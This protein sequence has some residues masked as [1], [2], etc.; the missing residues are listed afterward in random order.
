MLQP[1]R[2]ILSLVVFGSLL[3]GISFTAD[4][5]P[6]KRATD[7]HSAHTQK[8][9]KPFSSDWHRPHRTGY[10]QPGGYEGRIGSPYY[11]SIP[12][13]PAVSRW[14][15]HWNRSHAWRGSVGH[16]HSCSC[17]QHHQHHGSHFRGDQLR[18]WH[19]SQRLMSNPY[20]YHFGHGYYR[21]HEHGHYRF[22]YYSY[23]RPWF[24]PGPP[25]FNRDT[26]FAW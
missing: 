16:D 14:S 20:S 15:A 21:H 9:V 18:H 5:S 1:L 6:H 8:L 10:W 7:H 25:V 13:S 26:N 2:T 17:G 3:F 12:A 22:P 24:H 11:W 19:G 4:A 23:R